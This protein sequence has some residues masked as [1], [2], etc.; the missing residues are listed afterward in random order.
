MSRVRRGGRTTLSKPTCAILGCVFV[1]KNIFKPTL[2]YN[3][4][5]TQDGIELV[6]RPGECDVLRATPGSQTFL[7]PLE[8]AARAVQNSIELSR[9]LIHLSL[10]LFTA[11]RYDHCQTYFPSMNL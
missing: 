4:K 5:P 11:H 7:V 2:D 6:A 1:N 10:K 9:Q 8:V 3:K